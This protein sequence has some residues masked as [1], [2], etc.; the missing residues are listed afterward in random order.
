MDT[1]TRKEIAGRTIALTAYVNE[2]AILDQLETRLLKLYSQRY[3]IVN[4]RRRKLT[5][6]RKIKIANR[7]IEKAFEADIDISIDAI[8]MI[9]L[10][11]S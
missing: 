2:K 3:E 10:I 6:P 11:D 8:N 9:K 7:L 5:K 1:E 4:G